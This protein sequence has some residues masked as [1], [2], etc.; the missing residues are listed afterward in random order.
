MRNEPILGAFEESVNNPPKRS[1]CSHFVPSMSFICGVEIVI[2]L[3]SKKR[4]QPPEPL[5]L[6]V[7]IKEGATDTEPYAKGKA[8]LD[9]SGYTVV[10]DQKEYRLFPETGN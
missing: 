1:I 6:K 2:L 9:F 3:I 8:P 10:C 5:K 4:K 7:R